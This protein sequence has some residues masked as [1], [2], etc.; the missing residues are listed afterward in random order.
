LLAISISVLAWRMR[1]G[2]AFLLMPALTL[3]GFPVKPNHLSNPQYRRG[4]G[5]PMAKLETDRHNGSDPDLWHSGHSSA[6][7]RC[8][9]NTEFGTG[10]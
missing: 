4:L 6:M 8:N 9:S 1:L 10:D 5:P 7:S 2:P 3:R